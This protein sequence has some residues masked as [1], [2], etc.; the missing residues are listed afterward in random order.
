M[1]RVWKP[2]TSIVKHFGLSPAMELP[3]GFLVVDVLLILLASLILGGLIGE[4][5]AGIN[6]LPNEIKTVERLSWS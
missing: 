6:E 1:P 4:G 2:L 5:I 3:L